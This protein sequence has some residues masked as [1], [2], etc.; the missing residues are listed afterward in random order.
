MRR[1]LGTAGRSPGSRNLEPPCGTLRRRPTRT[2]PSLRRG[3]VRSALPMVARRGRRAARRLQTGPS[4]S[5]ATHPF[6]HSL[7]GL[8]LPKKGRRPANWTNA[9]PRG[10]SRTWVGS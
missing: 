2:A 3:K 10:S 6:T 8:T 9:V 5:V 1:P 7:T 4:Q